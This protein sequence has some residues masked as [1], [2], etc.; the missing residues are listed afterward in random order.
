MGEKGKAARVVETFALASVGNSTQKLYFAKRNTW[1]GER[2]AKG[3][4]P[5]LH[6]NPGNPIQA[7]YE[8]TEFMA[9]RSFVYN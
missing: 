7:L 9:C 4:G 1:V 3:K 5:W 8:L 6:H 2:A